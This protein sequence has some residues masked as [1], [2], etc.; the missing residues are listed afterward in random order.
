VVVE[1]FIA[2]EELLCNTELVEDGKRP[3]VRISC[4]SKS[5]GLVLIRKLRF[6]G[7]EAV[8]M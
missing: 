7:G 2:D 3:Y 5:S 1:E 6:F 4:G 8:M